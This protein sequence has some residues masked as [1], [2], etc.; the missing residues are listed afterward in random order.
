MLSDIFMAC[1]KCEAMAIYVVKQASGNNIWACVYTYNTKIEAKL[2]EN[3][4][5]AYKIILTNLKI[6]IPLCKRLRDLNSQ[7]L[8]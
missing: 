4:P 1:S 5:G 8:R 3:K 6:V 2:R 7:L